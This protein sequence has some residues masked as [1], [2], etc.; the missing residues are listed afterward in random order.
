[1]VLQRCWGGGFVA[2]FIGHVRLSFWLGTALPKHQKKKIISS[3]VRAWGCTSDS[4]RLKS[5]LLVSR[6]IVPAPWPTL[7]PAGRRQHIHES[8]PLWGIEQKERTSMR[9]RRPRVPGFS[10]MWLGSVQLIKELL[11]RLRRR[12]RRQVRSFVEGPPPARSAGLRSCN[13]SELTT[14]TLESAHG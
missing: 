13:A 1:V 12:V 9:T 5:E 11:L 6:S 14:P 10:H 3:R 2:L 7:S 4:S 8:A